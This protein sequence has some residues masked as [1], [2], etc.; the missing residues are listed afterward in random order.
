MADHAP[1]IASF[2]QRVFVAPNVRVMAQSDL[3]EA[4]E[5][6]LFGLREQLGDQAFPKSAGEYLNDWAAPERGWLRKFYPP[7]SDAV[8]FDPTL[9]TKCAFFFTP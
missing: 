7:A 2:L 3:V 8:H 5:D 9:A 1:L 4:L 6:T